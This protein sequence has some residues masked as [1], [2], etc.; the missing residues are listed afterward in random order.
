MPFHGTL[1]GGISGRSDASA[2]NTSSGFRKRRKLAGVYQSGGVTTILIRFSRW[3]WGYG[4]LH[5]YLYELGYGPSSDYGHF[6][7]N[8]HTR[9]G[10]C[11]IGTVF[12]QGV[13]TPF[14]TNYN[15]TNERCDI[16]ISSSSYY[17]YEV[18]AH[19]HSMSHMASD[20][21]GPGASGTNQW[22]LYSSSEVI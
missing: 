6:I 15:S 22:H 2:L 12:N 5:I 13:P 21:I 16:S 4:N 3:W 17:T 11:S 8:G 10:V 18:I 19:S 14:G 7:V 1:A 20:N 9:S